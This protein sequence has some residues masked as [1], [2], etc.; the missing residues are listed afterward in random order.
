MVAPALLISASSRPQS[1]AAKDD[2]GHRR[3][4]PRAEVIRKRRVVCRTGA[5]IWSLS[6]PDLVPSALCA[7][8]GMSLSGGNPLLELTAWLRDKHILIV[9]D[10][11]EHVI[12]AAAALAET[13]LKAAPGVSILTTSREPLRAEG[14]TL[15]RLAALDLPSNSVDLTA[16][17]AL[18]YSAIQLFNERAMAAAGDFS[19][20]AAVAVNGD[21][22]E[23]LVL[24]HI[25][26]LVAKS[27]VVT[28]LREELALFTVGT[29]EMCRPLSIGHFL[30]TATR[31]SGCR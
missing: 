1:E 13:I 5:P 14:E 21:L 29:S 20:D 23:A 22:S 25:A 19:L 17:D 27:L 30:P 2:G 26:N 11:C 28:N 3:R 31:R 8:L 9:L 15:H 16:A 24:N 4:R 6:G 7:V 18:R 10:N 12:G